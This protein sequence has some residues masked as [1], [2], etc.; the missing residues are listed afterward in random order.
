MRAQVLP[1]QYDGAMVRKGGSN[2]IQRFAI[3]C[4]DINASDFH[5][6]TADQRTSIKLFASCSR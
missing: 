1:A 6:E 2:F 5:A 4:R 3:G